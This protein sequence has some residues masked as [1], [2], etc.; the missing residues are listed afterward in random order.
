MRINDLLFVHGGISP[1]Y[2]NLT[3]RQFNDLVRRTRPAAIFFGHL[4]QP[5]AT[6]RLGSTDVWQVR[7]CC[8]NFNGAPVGFLHVRVGPAG[9]AVREI[10]V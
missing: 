3:V 6:Y 9:L 5:T 4:H 7:S 2:V 1:K 8:W 10:L